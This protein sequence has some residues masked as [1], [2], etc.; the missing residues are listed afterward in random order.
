MKCEWR[1]CGGEV[2]LGALISGDTAKSSRLIRG[3]GEV[4]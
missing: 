3:R 2:R 4:V 1:V